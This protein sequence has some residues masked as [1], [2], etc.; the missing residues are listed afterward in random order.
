TVS[1]SNAANVVVTATRV[2]TIFNPLPVLTNMIP[3]TATAG[4]AAL[5]LNLNGSGFVKT[6]SVLWNGASLA[7]GF[8][9][10]T[11]LTATLPATNLQTAG[12]F[13]VAVLSG[14]PG[15]G[16]STPLTF[17]VN[18]PAPHISNT[19]PVAAAKG[20]LTFTLT[21]NGSNFI[22]GA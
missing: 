2:I 18:N 20:G 13:T 14:G 11:S 7:A 12:F 1:V 10:S 19:V 9:T 5:T 16:L 15:G 3:F 22:T 17:T 4:D 8:V 21:V 6:S